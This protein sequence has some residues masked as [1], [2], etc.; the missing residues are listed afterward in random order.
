M[1]MKNWLLPIKEKVKFEIASPKNIQTCTF[2]AVSLSLIVLLIVWLVMDAKQTF[3]NIFFKETLYIAAVG[4]MSG[5]DQING[6]AMVQGVQLYLDKIN[7]QGGIDGKQIKLL[8]FDDQNQPD[9]AKRIATQI[10]TENQA[11]AV[12]GHYASNSSLAAAPIYQEHRIPAI[13]GSA[14]NDNITKNNDWYFRVIFNNS[15]QGAMLANYVQ[16]ILGHQKAYVFYDEDEYGRT[17]KDAF[18]QTAERIGLKIEKQLGFNQSSFAKQHQKM[19]EVLAGDVEESSILFLAT[20][21][22][23]A[24]KI[25]K[26][27]LLHF[28]TPIPIIGGDALTSRSFTQTF[29]N[30][31]QEQVFPGSYTDGIYAVSPFLI[32]MAGKQAQ[33]FQE[34]FKKYLKNQGQEASFDNQNLATVA[35]YYD[36]AMVAVDAVKKMLTDDQ[37]NKETMPEMRRGVHKQL[38]QLSNVKNALE[39]VTGDLYFNKNGDAIKYVPIGLYRKG[40]PTVA[41]FQYRPLSNLQT[42]DNLAQKILDK[43]I[44]QINDH[45]MQ[46]VHVVYVGLD[47]NQISD[48]DINKR[49]YTADF[50][51]WFRFKRND[52]E[53]IPVDYD[54]INFVNIYQAGN[55]KQLKEEELFVPIC[56]FG[57]D[58]NQSDNCEIEN[59]PEEESITRI[60]RVKTQFKI[61]FDFRDYPLD[62]QTL[63]IQ[64]RHKNLTTKDLIYVVDR[65]GLELDNPDHERNMDNREEGSQEDIFY[66]GGEWEIKNVSF[67]QDSQ[68]NDSTLGI[69]RL[70]DL[71][72]RLEYSRFNLE[73]EIGRDVWRFILKNLLPILFVLTLGYLAYWTDE[74]G[75]KMMLN[76]NLILST[77]LFHLK[78][79]SG[80]L[81]LV[82]YNVLIEWAFYVIYSLAIVGILAALFF[83]LKKGKLGVR[84]KKLEKLQD[85]LDKLND[86]KDIN[87]EAYQKIQNEIKEVKDDIE[88]KETFIHCINQWGMILY[89][90][91]LFTAFLIIFYEHLF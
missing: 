59:S 45:F 89:P 19:I 38:L 12:I 2:F 50:Y 6:K 60:Y 16:K 18:V 25:I 75:I 86:L 37:V 3:V 52:D 22:Q 68:R 51:L 46:Q 28:E 33:R 21:S 70:F 66:F 40:K 58:K 4:P 24:V 31:P 80:E 64:F 73:A 17:L 14:T 78:L 61:R 55:R 47:V 72:G 67:F 91:I 56:P 36:A 83:K 88:K 54:A 62:R 42:I 39:G 81:A 53:Q 26:S 90:F 23:E 29:K 27:L 43:E 85:R 82:G 30:D 71:H 20:H 7:R 44:I 65:Q 34:E 11:L 76:V 8:E 48:L 57:D 5:P 79:S 10:A 13:T 77:S 69:P 63:S 84:E 9:E 1:M 15:E 49:N 87:E 41:W 74:F 35:L 32:D